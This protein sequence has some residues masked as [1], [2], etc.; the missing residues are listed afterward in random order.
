[1]QRT[2]NDWE[3]TEA[4]IDSTWAGIISYS[5][6]WR[7]H[8]GHVP[9]QDTQFYYGWFQ[10]TWHACHLV[11]GEGAREYGHPGSCL[12]K[13]AGHASC[14]LA[15]LEW[16]WLDRVSATPGPSPGPLSILPGCLFQRRGKS[17]QRLIRSKVC[18][19]HLDFSLLS[20]HGDEWRPRADNEEG[21]QAR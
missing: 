15:D 1:M 8:V 2:F 14:F 4:R 9:V 20:R 7:P 11:S 18:D 16:A 3:K 10:R 12:R 6:N 17:P 19:A 5:Y 13:Q 21:I